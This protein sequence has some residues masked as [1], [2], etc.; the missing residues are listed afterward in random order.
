MPMRQLEVNQ[1]TLMPITQCPG[2]SAPP[3]QVELAF[4][5]RA[6]GKTDATARL[7]YLPRVSPSL[8]PFLNSSASVTIAH[9]VEPS[10]MIDSAYSA[11]GHSGPCAVCRSLVCAAAAAW[12]RQ[13]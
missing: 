5:R 6:D 10:T 12:A 1:E 9:V 8:S 3:P 11:S 7:L 2:V 4:T 13:S